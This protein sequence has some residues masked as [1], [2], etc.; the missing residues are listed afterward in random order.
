[1][2]VLRAV[3]GLTSSTVPLLSSCLLLT[4]HFSP[5]AAQ[6]QDNSFLLEEAY[7]QERGVVQHISTFQRSRGGDWE[8]GFVQ[9]WPVGGIRHQL[10]YDLALHRSARLGTGL[11]DVGLNYRFQ[12]VGS[13][14]SRTVVAPRFSLLLPTGDE[15]EGRGAGALGFQGNLPVTL[16]LNNW[17]VT[18]WNAGGTITPSAR[19]ALGER[20]TT[21]GFNLG[22]SLVWLAAPSFNFLLEALWEGS[23]AVIGS[24]QTAREEGWVLSPGF[25][26]AFDLPS[27]LQ[28]VP[29]LAYTFGLG[30]DVNEDALFLYLSFEHP[31]QR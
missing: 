10:S 27:G 19:N 16:V 5:L 26:A 31:F 22:G 11:G 30:P 29:G 7:N 17:L 12:L 3:R 1:V 8:L 13:P 2:D 9:E 4:S 24:G 18:H 14:E 25:R 28:I 6:I 20:A 21:A 15:R 23:E